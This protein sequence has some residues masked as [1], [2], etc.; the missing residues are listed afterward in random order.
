MA[1]GPTEPLGELKRSPRTP[2]RSQGVGALGKGR[3][4]G[5][6]R[7]GRE[8]E[9]GKG[10]GER[11]GRGREKGWEGREREGREEGTERGPQFKKND[12]PSLD[13]WLRAC[14]VPK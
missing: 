14:L 8:G 6:G 10:R 11:D 13:G 4:K 1:G 2:S 5:K 9:G 3:E 7:E 12:P